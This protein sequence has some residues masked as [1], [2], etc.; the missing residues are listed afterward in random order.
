MQKTLQEDYQNVKDSLE[1]TEK[2]KQR[3]A[4]NFEAVD[5]E[6]MEERKKME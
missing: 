1:M 6:N 3:A 4:A 5:K 2:L